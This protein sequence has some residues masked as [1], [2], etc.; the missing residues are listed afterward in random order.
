MAEEALG[1][2]GMTEEARRIAALLSFIS[3]ASMASRYR[4]RNDM[5]VESTPERSFSLLFKSSR[6]ADAIVGWGPAGPRCGVVIMAFKVASIGRLRSDRKLVTPASVL[7][8]S[9]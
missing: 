2:H 1:E 6:A 3:R 4:P 5:A 9:A 8:V 7:F